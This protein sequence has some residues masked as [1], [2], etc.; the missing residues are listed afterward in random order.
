MN[1]WPGQQIQEIADGIVAIVH[2]HGEVGVSNASFIIEGQRTFVVDS[3]T[4]PEM[5]TGMAQ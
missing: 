3:M 4:F 5:A 1:T 2:G